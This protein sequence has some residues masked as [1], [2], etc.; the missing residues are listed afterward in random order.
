[1]TISIVLDVL[2]VQDVKE[3]L[4]SSSNLAMKKVTLTS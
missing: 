3:G 1:M 2:L 4:S